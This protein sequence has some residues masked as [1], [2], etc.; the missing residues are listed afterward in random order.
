MIS[1][2][3]SL[4]PEKFV[5]CLWFIHEANMQ[6]QA[7]TD[8]QGKKG[9]R[10]TPPRTRSDSKPPESTTIERIAAA[11]RQAFASSGKAAEKMLEKMEKDAP[12][13]KPPGKTSSGKQPG[14]PPADAA[15]LK[16]TLLAKL[17][18]LQRREDKSA[19]VWTDMYMSDW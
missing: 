7:K 3:V 17:A 2:S 6:T 5:G 19:T 11:A 15:T 13:V 12:A 9:S 16:G 10:Y 4:Q 8:R 1:C 18:D 14:K